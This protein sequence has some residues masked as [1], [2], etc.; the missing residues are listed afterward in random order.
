MKTVRLSWLVI[1][2]LTLS[3]G[4]VSKNQDSGTSLDSSIIDKGTD[5]S[6]PDGPSIDMA[7]PDQALLDSHHPDLPLPD[8][9]KPD[10]ILLDTSQPDSIL[11]DMPAPDSNPPDMEIPDQAQL[12]KTIPDLS[13]PD[14]LTLD[15]LVPDQQMVPDM[16]PLKKLIDDTFSDF[17]KGTLSESG[18]K[19]YIS[20]KG[21]IQLLDRLDINS[22]GWSDIILAQEWDGSTSKVNSYIYWGSKT[23]FSNTNR[24]E[25]PTI[26]AQNS[27]TGDFNNDGKVDVF[28][29]NFGDSGNYQINS[30]VYWQGSTS[31]NYTKTELPTFGAH[32]CSVS[33]LNR[34]GYLDLVVSNFY[35][36]PNTTP[37][38]YIYYGSATGFSTSNRKTIQASQAIYNSVA[39]F[40]KD[41]YLD[42]SFATYNANSII[43]YGD[44]QNAFTK[45]ITLPTSTARGVTV[46]DLNKD[47]AL[48]I[49]FTNH[50]NGNFK[51]QMM[52]SI[53]WGATTGF[54]STN[55]S[56]FSTLGANDVSVGD[57]NAD[58]NLDLAISNVQDA[59]GSYSINSYIYWGTGTTSVPPT[60]TELPTHGADSNLIAD[61]N[62]DSVL[63]ILFAN[64]DA[65][66]KVQAS[67]LYFGGPSGSNLVSK[68]TLPG[69]FSATLSTE[70]GSIYTRK[71]VQ[72]LISQVH[73]SQIPSPNYLFL[74]WVAEIPA[75]TSL[76]FRVRSATTLSA[77]PS[78]S[79]YG[80]T[81]TTD[82]Y[83]ATTSASPNPS[84]S[85]GSINLNQ[86][87]KGQPFIQYQVIFE[88]GNNFA[89]TPILDKVEVAYY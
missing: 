73:T 42:L 41:G 64:W 45:S 14:Q 25:L 56:D 12:D 24:V 82:Y 17:G 23:G 10:S 81:S 51:Y 57:L 35:G 85:G 2:G 26:G 88:Q 3:C 76:K 37:T 15:Q 20:A 68:S 84:S 44:K 89:N 53:F 72:T 16:P 18:G 1:L 19:I 6:V 36:A 78:A 40:D 66:Q 48:D 32:G 75:K 29:S 11:I 9:T 13:L 50:W 70:P 59:P 55:R 7:T 87:H 63:D 69:K 61:F 86:I 30:Y 28:F 4:E 31:A 79:W 22:D 46:A 65:H 27:C 83:Q 21:N 33:D 43:Y 52:S 34:D 62:G 8:A 39:D 38:S 77:L 49:I 80:P 60:R 67:Y 47:N 54:T 74:S 58:G 71:P 5:A